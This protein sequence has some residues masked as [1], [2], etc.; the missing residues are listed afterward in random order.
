MPL[1]HVMYKFYGDDL[2]TLDKDT[3]SDMSEDIATEKKEKDDLT[4]CNYLQLEAYRTLDRWNDHDARILLP[5]DGV[6][7]VLLSV[8]IFGPD[9]VTR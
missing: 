1:D 3:L 5:F 8:T 9:N 2:K 6:I 4:R 7:L